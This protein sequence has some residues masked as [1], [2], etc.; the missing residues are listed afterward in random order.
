MGCYSCC[1]LG[2]LKWFVI[3]ALLSLFVVDLGS[4][5]QLVVSL[6]GNTQVGKIRNTY[7]HQSVSDGKIQ[8]TILIMRRG[9]C[10]GSVGSSA[11][12]LAQFYGVGLTVNIFWVLFK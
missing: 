5:G 6:F 11:D 4:V 12:L 10:L 7:E 3:V 2:F 8:I 1:Q 9:P